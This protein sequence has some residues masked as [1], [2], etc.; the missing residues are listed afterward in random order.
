MN[1]FKNLVLNEAFA[2]I[3][4]AISEPINTNKRTYLLEKGIRKLGWRAIRRLFAYNISGQ[5]KY[6]QHNA[7]AQLSTRCL[8]LYYD[9]PQIGDALMDLAPRSLIHGL[10]IKIDLYTHTHIAELFTNDQWINTIQTDPSK[11]NKE[12]YDFVIVSSFKWRSI[13]HKLRYARKLPWISIFEKFSGPEI[14]RA[15]YSTKKLAETFGVTLNR[16]AIEQHS[17]QKLLYK[18]ES[19]NIQQLPN[20]VT[21]AIG[22]ADPT[23]TY[24]NWQDVVIGLKKLGVKSITLVGSENGVAYTERIC[25]LQENGF[26]I[27]NYVGKTSLRKCK[28]LMQSTSAIIAADGGLMHLAIT[29]NKPV[30]SLF[31]NAIKPI[32]RLPDC[33]LAYSIQSNTKDINNISSNEIINTVQKAFLNCTTS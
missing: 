28:Q 19:S 1:L 22:G 7:N 13:K 32:W 29:C 16:K 12:N 9:V 10:G 33:L 31:N 14:N 4:P 11:I 2:S 18:H 25:A 24:E 26:Q 27:F 15:L 8:W 23:R 5:K 30:V 3:S 20:S 6:F 17:H 21:L